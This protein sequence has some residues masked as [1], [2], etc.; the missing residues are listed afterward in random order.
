MPTIY[1]ADL[2]TNRS[3]VCHEHCYFEIQ[4]SLDDVVLLR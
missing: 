2:T 1:N 3:K 4:A